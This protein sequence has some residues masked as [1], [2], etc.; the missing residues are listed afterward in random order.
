M[1]LKEII[2]RLN[3]ALM[4]K[5]KEKERKV[6]LLACKQDLAAAVVARVQYPSWWSCFS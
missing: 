5:R 3:C 6:C 2:K 4:K 1:Q